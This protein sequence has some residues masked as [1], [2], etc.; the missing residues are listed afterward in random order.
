MKTAKKTIVEFLNKAFLPFRKNSIN[1]TNIYAAKLIGSSSHNFYVENISNK[2][3][4]LHDRIKE[5][6]EECFSESYM[7]II[8]NLRRSLRLGLCTTAI[9]ITH[10][11]FFGAIRGFDIFPLEKDG[12]TGEFR[13][14]VISLV[15]KA[16]TEKFPV[17]AIPFRLGQNSARTVEQLLNIAS[18]LL[19]RVKLVL[20]D[21]GFYSAEVIDVLNTRVKYLI[22]VPQWDIY[23]SMLEQLKAEDK[24][25]EYV[26][27]ELILSKDFSKF[28][29]KTKIILIN[30]NEEFDWVFATNLPND[31]ALYY[32]ITYKQRWQIETN[33]RVQDE[34]RIRSRSRFM[35]VRYF[36]FLVSL[37][38]HAIW[39]VKIRQQGLSFSVFLHYLDRMLFCEELGIEY[40]YVGEG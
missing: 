16:E 1:A 39:I 13:F 22:L 9:D 12:K 38:L 14:A 31:K 18:R 37:L 19:I 3:D 20:L 29:V 6:Y 25:I 27:H 21:R 32:I 8:G 26:E 2:A 4:R 11:N 10:E 24:I 23:K 28:K 7:C 40:V 30:T 5:S 34:A 15:N 17:Y 36:Y 33:F 35:Q